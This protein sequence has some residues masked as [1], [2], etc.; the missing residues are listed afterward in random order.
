MVTAKRSA[1]MRQATGVYGKMQQ[2][3]RLIIYTMKTTF[4]VCICVVFV[5]CLYWLLD[6]LRSFENGVC[7]KTKTIIVMFLFISNKH[8][9][10]VIKTMS[11][12]IS[13]RI[14]IKMNSNNP[15][16]HIQYWCILFSTDPKMK[17]EFSIILLLHFPIFSSIFFS[18]CMYILL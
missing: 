15:S 1:Y 7:K 2:E 3:S 16:N 17:R 6:R 13:H 5:F 12:C 4:S 11:Y 18:S 9:S 8:Y 10:I 14:K